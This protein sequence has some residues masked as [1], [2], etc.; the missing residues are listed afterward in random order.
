[1]SDFVHLHLHSEYSL[2]DGACRI[3]DIPKKAKAEGHSAV[4]ITDH[5]VMYG[6]VAFYRACREEG[7]KPIIGCEVYVAPRTRFDR[8]GKLDSS[9]HHLVLL[10]E[11]EVGYRN[12]ITLVS[13]AFTEGF[14]SK[15]RIDMDLLRRHHEGLIALSACLAGKIPQLILAGDLRGAQAYALEMQELFGRDRFYLEVQ[16]HYL[17]EEKTVA[18]AIRDIAAQTGIPMVAT[19]DAHYI[20]KKDAETQAILMCIQ[21]GNVISDGRPIGFETDEFYYKST[22][23]MRRLFGDYPGA[24]ENTVKIADMCNFDFIFGQTYL[25][26]FEPPKGK[27]HKECLADLA[28]AGFARRVQARDITFSRDP[29]ERYE[30]RIEYELSVIDK[31]G[32]NAYF[33]I[34]Q[35]F[36]NYAKD[37]G[38][39]VGP[40]RGSGAGS[41]VAFCIGITDVDPLRYDLLFERFLNPERVSL[42]DFDIDFCYDRRG[43]V[44]EYVQQKYGKDHVAQIATFGT[45]AARAA[46][47]DVGRALGMPYGEVDK[48][49]RLIPHEMNVTI[50]DAM[51]RKEL[52]VLY[53]ESREV[54]RLLDTAQALEGMPRHA[55]THAAG[56][57]ITEKPTDYYVPLSTNGDTI[58]TQYDMDTDA[59]LGLVKF[60]FLGLRYLTILADAEREIRRRDPNF[61][62]ASVPVDDAATFRLIGEGQT[63]GIFQLE[64]AGMRQ[65]LTQLKPSS[66][67]DIIAAIALYRPGPMDSIPRYIACRNGTEKVH[68]ATPALE[69]IL[70]VTNGCIVYQ[71][72][73]MQICRELAGYSFAHADIVRRAMAKKKSDVMLAERAQFKAGAEAR[74]VDG[75]VAD[76][77]FDEMV[78]FASY[79]FNKSHAAAYAVISYRT[80]YLKTHHKREYMAALMTSVLTDATKLGEYI[81]E[82]QRAGIAVL[83]PDINE[84]D[85]HFSVSGDHIRFGLLAIKNVGRIFVEQILRERKNG[86]FTSFEDFVRR[87]AGGELNRRQVEALIKC[88]AF[89]GLGVYRSRLLAAYETIL[90]NAAAR[91][92]T[93]LTGQFDLFSDQTEVL[94]GDSFEYPEL[95]EFNIRELLM[96]EKESA[97]MSFSGHLLD[98]FSE[99]VASLKTE[100]ISSILQS[101]SEETGES[102]LYEDKQTLRIA[103]ILSKRVNKNTRAGDP[104]AFVTLEDRYGEMEVVVFP[105][106]LDRFATELFVEN[107]I[108]AEGTLSLREG[109]AP[110]LLLSSVFRLKS[111]EN[112]RKTEADCKNEAEKKLYV[113]LPSLSA[114]NTDSALAILR[115]HRGATPVLFFGEAERRYVAVKDTGVEVSS[116]LLAVL[117]ARFG[118]K[119]VVIQ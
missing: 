33:L 113:K 103:G 90:E 55:S 5:G 56:V 15:P 29:R 14:Y 35:D 1:M 70:G 91:V 18:E 80:A 37:R 61:R 6:A 2:L 22:E 12:L 97:G 67:E 7:I 69:K 45:M 82:C 40:G 23:E 99:H 28:R 64:S 78:S 17:P 89:D 117:R 27:T 51:K 31:M 59:A 71:E 81:A 79:A 43:E 20:E 93:N 36:V 86:L 76:A 107:A 48:V 96:L 16:D 66:M 25:P 58:V 50:A 54:R 112:V 77:I 75:A 101:Y 94:G 114:E 68:Y 49:A 30:E 21:T 4:A 63:G 47:R 100:P 42:P 26:S 24:L 72:Q 73:V 111:N 88:G 83:A 104:M 84:S 34:V 19:N 106:V 13:R 41:L 74:G 32:F 8:E 46:V 105:K 109:E 95:P 60:D 65:M 44:I 108:C 9:G 85:L 57:V 115:A 3:T 11:N 53:D 118:D 52:R 87:M 98:D 62:L 39:P 92:R 116:A 10:V 38:I 110:K 102:E 119:N